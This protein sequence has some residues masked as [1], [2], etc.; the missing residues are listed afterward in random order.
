MT[1]KQ[2]KLWTTRNGDRVRICDMDDDHL[3]NTMAFLHR[4][5]IME[6]SEAVRTM[7][8]VIPPSAE[9]ASLDFERALDEALQST[10]EDYVPEIFY[11]LNMDYCR[12]FG[13]F[14]NPEG[15]EVKP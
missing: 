6:C 14:W 2:T 12:R 13:S 8:H 1:R 7:L 5:A 11:D 15:Q 9:M 4:K 10:W 3:R